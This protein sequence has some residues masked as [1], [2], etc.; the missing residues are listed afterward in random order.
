[1]KYLRMDQELQMPKKWTAVGGR[2]S[3]EVASEVLFD[4]V[5]WNLMLELVGFIVACFAALIDAGLA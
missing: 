3:N 2:D 4:L 5:K 1:M